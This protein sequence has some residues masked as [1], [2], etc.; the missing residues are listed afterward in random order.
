MES[1]AQTVESREQ[2]TGQPINSD[3][4]P[5]RIGLS[6]VLGASWVHFSKSSVLCE[7]SRRFYDDEKSVYPSPGQVTEAAGTELEAI[8]PSKLV[9]GT[10]VRTSSALESAFRSGRLFFAQR[11]DDVRSLVDRSYAKYHKTERSITTTASSLHDRSEDLL[12]NSIYVVVAALSGNIAARQRGI[13]SKMV[14]P[15]VFG[16]AA[17]KYFLPHT[18]SN[19]AQ[20]AWKLEQENLPHIAKRQLYVVDSAA[21][22]VDS[23]EQT[24]KGGQEYI[25]ST[26][27][28]LKKSITEVTGVDVDADARK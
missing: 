26:V 17:F 24:T 22:I 12:P 4:G 21:G 9:D 5:A 10:S 20:F 8:G 6:V 27:E 11:V 25:D 2:T 16:L 3:M 23:V 19:T 18:F 15:V 1:R 14:F 7:S 28:S 13:F